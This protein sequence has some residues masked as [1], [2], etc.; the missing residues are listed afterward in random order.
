MISPRR[1]LLSLG[2]LPFF[3]GTGSHVYSQQPINPLVQPEK[4]IKLIGSTPVGMRKTDVVRAFDRVKHA[5]VNIHSERTVS[6]PSVDVYSI[7]PHQNRVNGMG[8]GI[9]I[10]PRGFIITNYHVVEDVSLLRIRL[11]D[12]TSYNAAIMARNPELDL[13]LIKIDAPQPLPTIPIG[14]S[15]DL[16]I[17][18]V[19]IAVGNAFGYEHTVSQGIIAAVKRDVTLNKDMAYKSL[20]QTDA[21]INPG[22]SGGPLV[23]ILGDCVGV[24]VA[25]RAG[26]QNIGFAIPVDQMVKAAADMLRSRRRYGTYDGLQVRDSVEVTG[27]T[28][29]RSVVLDRAD[30]NSPAARAGLKTG[31]VLLQ[32]ADTKIACSFDVER[33]LIERKAG[34]SLPIVYRRDQQEQRTDLV[35][36]GPDSPFRVVSKQPT[37]TAATTTSSAPA[38]PVWNKLGMQLAPAGEDT[39]T[40]V[41]K[42]LKGGLEIT[43]VGA[44]TAAYKAGIRK[45]DILVG[46]HTWEMLTI[47][48]VQY[49]LSHP[50]LGTFNPLS[51]YI[52]RAGQVR[53]GSLMVP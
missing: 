27:E 42:G 33:A 26:A 10:D 51:F 21:A 17:G 11:W 6:S 53:R 1:F 52:L 12:G 32:I 48:N 16:M 15:Q 20:I 4:S 28:P 35:M 22:N 40:K 49:V 18:E 7:T 9:I 37:P 38:D 19:V 14:S 3:L 45:G 50:D 36:S 5:V 44:D 31:D 25:I 47:E 2:T 24:N 8:T 30:T 39:V 23:N 43:N 29:I 13:A 41:N 34:E 46:L